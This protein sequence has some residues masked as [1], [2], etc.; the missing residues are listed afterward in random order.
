MSELEARFDALVAGV[1]VPALKPLGYR[2]R[3]LSW[4]RETPEAV[5][6]ITLQRSQGNAPDHLRFYVEVN[7]YV[8]DFARTVGATVPDRLEKATPQYSRRFESVIDWPGQ[9]IDLESWTDE[10]LHPA[11]DEALLKLDGHL[12]AID[13]APALAEALRSGGP[14]NLDLFAWWCATGNTE[15]QAAQ[16]AAAQAEF[17]QED[18]WPRLLAQ[19]ERT[20]GRFGVVLPSG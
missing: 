1:V 8:P 19:F 12:A 13:T 18:R 16:L 4:S 9:W 20:A 10:D 17:G 11:F 15:E 3:K 5:H 6:G 7:A 14:L 2:K